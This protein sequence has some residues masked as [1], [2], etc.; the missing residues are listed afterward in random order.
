MVSQVLQRRLARAHCLH[1][2]A[3]H[4]KHREAPVLDLFDLELGQRVRVVRQTERIKRLPGVQR[5]EPLAHGA[6]VDAVALNERHQHDLHGRRRDDRLRVDQGAV[7]Q[8]VEPSLAEDGGSGPEPNCSVLG[9][10][11]AKGVPEDLGR[12]AAERAEHG[13]AGV[14]DLDLAVAGK[15]LRVGRE[16]RGVPAV[17]ARVLPV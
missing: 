4:R 12:D 8:I 11:H 17:V 7:P 2:E 15:R 1:E 3:E 9:E 14:D 16:A 5:V 13:P 6:P 10:R